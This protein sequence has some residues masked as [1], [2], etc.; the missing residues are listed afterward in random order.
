[1]EVVDMTQL[2]QEMTILRRLFEPWNTA[3]H[4]TVIWEPEASD[5]NAQLKRDMISKAS[6]VIAAGE[7][8]SAGAVSMPPVFGES[9]FEAIEDSLAN[10]ADQQSY[11]ELA[12]ACHRVVQSLERIAS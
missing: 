4:G 1:M 2:D 9:E 7:N 10:D 5:A 3:P 11:Y 6:K 8:A 12:V